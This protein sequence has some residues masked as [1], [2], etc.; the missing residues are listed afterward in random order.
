M[1]LQL[2][3][4]G[5]ITQVSNTYKLR[6]LVT[7]AL[8]G[9]ERNQSPIQ[10]QADFSC[11]TCFKPCGL[12][13]KFCL[14]DVAKE[15]I[16][17]Y[18]IA[19]D[20]DGRISKTLLKTDQHPADD[21]SILAAVCL[22]KLSLMNTEKDTESLAKTTTTYLLQAAVLLETAWLHSKHNFQISLMLIRLYKHLGCGSLAMRAYHRLSL[23][24]IQLDTLTYTIFDRLSSSHPHSWSQFTETSSKQRTSLEQLQKQ[25][26]LYKSS[27]ENITKNA[28][29]SFKHGSYNAIFEMREVSEKL[30]NSMAAAM[31]VIES[32]KISRLT[33]PGTPMT[34]ISHGFDILRKSSSEN[35]VCF[36]LNN[37]QRRIW[38]SQ[39]LSS[40]IISITKP[41]QISRRAVAQDSKSLA[42]I[43]P[44]SQYVICPKT[45]LH[46]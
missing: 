25:Q 27:R 2:S 23:K 7:C 32:R 26:K 35:C 24:N 42:A 15:A 20:D 10:T 33:E 43:L 17:S 19:M 8:P 41:S 44:V 38:N 36:Q 31:S 5:K 12:S 9:H 40:P 37:S 46:H 18:R 6:Y 30:S 16:Q 34:E 29:L 3:T 4:A 14:E 1:L 39:T 21:L 45:T 13:C 28:W 11:A 22:I